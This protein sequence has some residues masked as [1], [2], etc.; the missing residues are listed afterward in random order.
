V[1]SSSFIERA[2]DFILWP[3]LF[4]AIRQYGF[5]DRFLE[6]LAILLPSASTQV[7]IN[8]ESGPQFGTGV[9]LCR[10]ACCRPSSSSLASM[11]WGASSNA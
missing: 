8:E 3:F 11:P 4:K 6:W 9:D 1:S 10:V 2:L 5:G 7:L